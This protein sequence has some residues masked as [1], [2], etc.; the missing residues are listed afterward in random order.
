MEEVHSAQRKVNDLQTHLKFLESKLAERDAEIRI[1]QENKGSWHRFHHQLIII[2]F[3]NWIISVSGSSFESYNS[4][5]SPMGYNSSKPPYNASN[6]SFNTVM[7]SSMLEQDS[8]GNSNNNYQQSANA[9]AMSQYMQCQ[10]YATFKDS[11]SNLPSNN[12]LMTTGN[13]SPNSSNY[14]YNYDSATSFDNLTRKSIDDHMKNQLDEQLLTKV[15]QM[16]L[17]RVVNNKIAEKQRE[18]HSVSIAAAAA[19]A[20][21]AAAANKEPGRS[22]HGYKD[23]EEFY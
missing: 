4:Y 16:T 1:L 17:D 18:L 14:T 8:N 11:G 15:S 3:I 5:L 12:L 19:A 2:Y 22:C 9:N 7:G 10:N 6:N 20:A 21:V 13:Y 23:R